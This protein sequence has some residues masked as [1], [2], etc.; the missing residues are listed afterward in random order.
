[1]SKDIHIFYNQNFDRHCNI[2]YYIHSL[3]L[4]IYFTLC[5]Q[6]KYRQQFRKIYNL[7]YILLKEKLIF[8][9]KI[10]FMFYLYSHFRLLG[11]RVGRCIFRF[12]VFFGSYIKCKFEC[13]GRLINMKQVFLYY[14]NIVKKRVVLIVIFQDIISKLQYWYIVDIS[15]SDKYLLQTLNSSYMACGNC[16]FPK[17][18]KIP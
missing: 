5:I 14:R 13:L 9:I 17:S 18:Y 1:M 2:L 15:L 4:L 12:G 16:W 6:Y 3:V 10:N 8:L 11:N 7:Y